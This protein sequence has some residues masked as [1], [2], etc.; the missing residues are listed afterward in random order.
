MLLRLFLAAVGLGFMTLCGYCLKR[1]IQFVQR[2]QTV[3]GTVVAF[4]MQA[5][6]ASRNSYRR[7]AHP[8]ARFSTATGQLVEADGPAGSLVPELRR[9]Q[10]ITLRYDPANPQNVEFPD[11]FSRWGGVM[12]AVGAAIFGA[13]CLLAAWH[14]AYD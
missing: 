4:E 3:A 7:V 11:V 5:L 2:A 13:G 9:G 1:K 14:L 8:V 12:L 6:N 10:Q